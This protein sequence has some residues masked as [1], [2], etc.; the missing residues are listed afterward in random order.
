MKKIILTNTQFKR[1]MV[2][3]QLD[4]TDGNTSPESMT[5]ILDLGEIDWGKLSRE[6]RESV[7]FDKRYQEYIRNLDTSLSSPDF[8]LNVDVDQTG[9]LKNYYKE[10]KDKIK[11]HEQTPRSTQEIKNLIKKVESPEWMDKEMRGEEGLSK[12]E[13]EKRKKDLKK[14]R[15]K[16]IDELYYEVSTWKNSIYCD[17]KVECCGKQIE[18]CAKNGS[19]ATWE[20]KTGAEWDRLSLPDDPHDKNYRIMGTKGYGYTDWKDIGLCRCV[21]SSNQEIKQSDPFTVDAAPEYSKEYYIQKQKYIEALYPDNFRNNFAGP[22]GFDKFVKE[23]KHEI[24]D[25]LSLAALILPQ[26]FGEIVSGIL[27]L[28]NA[29]I[30]EKDGEVGM[31]WVSILSAVLPGVISGIVKGSIKGSTSLVDAVMLW[32]KL[33]NIESKTKG[34]ATKIATE[35]LKSKTEKE[36]FKT[37]I[38][39]MDKL[40]DAILKSQ[41]GWTKKTLRSHIIQL[42]EYKKT[43]SWGK[44]VGRAFNEEFLE[45]L[46][47]KVRAKIVGFGYSIYGLAMWWASGGD[48]ETIEQLVGEY[49]IPSTTSD[50]KQVSK[51]IADSEMVEQVKKRLYQLMKYYGPDSQTKNTFGQ[52]VTNEDLLEKELDGMITSISN[53]VENLSNLPIDQISSDSLSKVLSQYNP[54]N[55]TNFKIINKNINTIKDKIGNK[56]ILKLTD[57]E[58]SEL[59]KNNQEEIKLSPMI[60]ISGDNSW[61]Y[62]KYKEYWFT[63]PKG[64]KDVWVLLKQNINKAALEKEFEDEDNRWA[65]PSDSELK[66]LIDAW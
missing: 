19:W 52:D 20:V 40:D 43:M 10:L 44:K 58:G 25:T 63:R 39:N 50:G 14:K 11:A 35:Y 51:I 65:Q 55:T 49:D 17:P 48:E 37:I 36:L 13:K 1:I 27:E 57:A 33:V 59:A 5:P 41:K 7:L 60:Y 62:V 2:N 9:G 42:G 24:I 22:N 6:E 16:E 61:E 45:H 21:S 18:Y 23:Y 56:D 32:K 46:P 29:G 3:E 28:A 38:K 54:N 47:L 66:A 64:S 30:Y 8:Q 12:S 26:P 4:A 53:I 31:K 34:V 15:Q